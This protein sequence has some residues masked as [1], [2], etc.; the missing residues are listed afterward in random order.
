MDNR[1]REQLKKRRTLLQ[2]K[3]EL[4]EI[5][6]RLS[7]LTPYLES[8]GFEYIIYYKNEYLIWL[9]ENL[10]IR[11]KDGYRGVHEDFQINVQ[12]AEAKEQTT[13][14]YKDV[15][16]Y[17][18]SNEILSLI[19]KDENFVLCQLGGDPDIEIPFNAFIENPGKFVTLRD[20]WLLSTKKDWIIENI[21]SLKGQQV[22]RFIKLIDSKPILYEVINLEID[23]HLKKN[24]NTT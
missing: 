1:R 7:Y 19:N 5:K 18:Q 22:I 2:K 10:D 13:I 4:K 17:L 8:A 16:S 12:D 9:Y 15:S 6:D 23:E 11:K 3:V 21:W 14:N 20:S 24:A